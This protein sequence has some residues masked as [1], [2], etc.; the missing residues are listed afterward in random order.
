[1]SDVNRFKCAVPGRSVKRLSSPAFAVILC[2]ISVTA[3]LP[4]GAAA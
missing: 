1:M 4:A 2:V 3:N